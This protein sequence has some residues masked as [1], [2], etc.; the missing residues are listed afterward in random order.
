MGSHFNHT[1]ILRSSME[2]FDRLPRDIG[3]QVR[4]KHPYEQMHLRFLILPTYCGSDMR[5]VQEDYSKRSKNC[6][7]YKMSPK[8]IIIEMHCFRS[9]TTSFSMPF[10]VLVEML[11]SFLLPHKS[12]SLRFGSFTLEGYFSKLP[13]ISENFVALVNNVFSF[14]H[15][16]GPS[17]ELG[18]K[19]LS[20]L[21]E[22]VWKNETLDLF[23][24]PPSFLHGWHSTL[25]CCAPA[26]NKIPS[27]P[28]NDPFVS[29]AR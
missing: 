24:W 25:D 27:Y 20:N 29:P 19:C 8:S 12:A 6:A 5:C 13:K 2:R 15:F 3:R 23:Y 26:H 10:N 9:R 28:L 14:H 4:D 18:M 22:A 7:K 21:P 16:E 1:Q 17:S 11:C